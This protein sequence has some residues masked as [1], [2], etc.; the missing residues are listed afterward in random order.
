[1]QIV[2]TQ[3]DQPFCDVSTEYFMEFME[4]YYDL[5]LEDLK[6]C[7]LNPDAKFDDFCRMFLYERFVLEHDN[8]TDI[9]EYD[10]PKKMYE[11]N[12]MTGETTCKN[13]TIN[14]AELENSI[15]NIL[16]VTFDDINEYHV[17]TGYCT[18]ER[19]GI[20]NDGAEPEDELECITFDIYVTYVML[21]DAVESVL[22]VINR[23]ENT[24]STSHID[25]ADAIMYSAYN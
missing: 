25:M 20:D 8:H 9:I 13:H 11:K 14:L 2:N 1:M 6:E 4:W 15:T 16:D 10:S 23:L 22:H 21:E 5:T 3:K 19:L 17:Y 7:I 24:M 12:I 18:I